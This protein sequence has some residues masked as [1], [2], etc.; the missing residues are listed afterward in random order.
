MESVVLF[1]AGAIGEAIIRRV[2]A[3]RHLVLADRNEKNLQDVAFRLRAAGYQVTT[4][5]VDIAERQAIKK[6]IQ[7]AESFGPIVHLIN[8]AG[9]SPSQATIETILAVDL[10]GTAV[11]LEEFG[12]VIAPGSSGIVISSQSGH[13]L[14]ALGVKNDKLLALTPT[15]ELKHLAL[16]DPQKIADPLAAYQLAKRANI[17]RVAAESVNWSQ[18]GARINAISPGIVMTPLALD[19]L[20]GPRGAGYHKMFNEM[21]EKRPATPD[22]IADL[23]EF[24]LSRKAAFIT[25]SDYLIDGGISAKYWFGNVSEV[26]K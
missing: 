26:R 21:V 7:V 19:E 14:P 24:L 16:L 18:K 12:K 2:G 17:L 4:V 25:G 1:G 13:R 9:V 3:N 8:A 10:Y 22:E 20:N 6:V 5:P 11:I 15:D 23:A